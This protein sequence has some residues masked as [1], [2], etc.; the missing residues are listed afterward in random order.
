MD[1]NYYLH[2]LSKYE[3]LREVCLGMSFT[4]QE[5]KDKVVGLSFTAYVDL[6][7]LRKSYSGGI[8]ERPNYYGECQNNLAITYAGGSKGELLTQMITELSL[9]HEL[10]HSFGSDHD[11]KGPCYGFL[12]SPTTFPKMNY[13]N[14]MF[15]PCSKKQIS[16]ILQIKSFC[17]EDTHEP[18]CGNG[19]KANLCNT[20]YLYFLFTI[21]IVPFHLL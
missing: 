11:R 15:S 2:Y 9:A 6:S 5:F 19:K 14:F 1:G 4:A 10:G 21:D 13:R 7:D 3:I 16:T 17:M 12:M 18:F 8:C 20:F